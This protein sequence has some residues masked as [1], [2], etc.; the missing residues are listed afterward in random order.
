VLDDDLLDRL[1]RAAFGYFVDAINPTNGLVADTSRQGSP[2]SIAVVGLALSTYPVAVERGWL[3]R[4]DA[5][6]RTLVT[7]RFFELSAQG[8]APDV[9][10]Y[11]GFYYHF[12]D[13]KSGKRAWGCEVSPIDTALLFAGILTAAAYFTSWRT[14]CITRGK[15]TVISPGT[16]PP[17]CS[18]SRISR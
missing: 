14:R 2:A 17:N 8:S 6:G 1:E 15:S 10:G 16:R 12:L 4:E 5:A 13:L 18:A 11:K 3:T 7:L 9:T